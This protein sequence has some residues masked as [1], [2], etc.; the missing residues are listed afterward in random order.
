LEGGGDPLVGVRCFWVSWIFQVN[1]FSS[2]LIY[3]RYGIQIRYQSKCPVTLTVK[4]ELKK[5]LGPK[6]TTQYPSSERGDRKSWPVVTYWNSAEIGEV[7]VRGRCAPVLL[8][9][10]TTADNAFEIGAPF[11]VNTKGIM[12]PTVLTWNWISADSLIASCLLRL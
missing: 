10:V 12:R 3:Q 8:F 9:Q 4:A 2:S 5:M 1:L 7:S 11:S 6:D